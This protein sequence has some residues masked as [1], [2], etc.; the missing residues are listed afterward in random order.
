MTVKRTEQH[1]IRQSHPAWKTIDDYCFRSKNLYNYTNY[2]ARQELIE[3]QKRLHYYDMW[4]AVKDSE[5][6]KNMGS[7]VGIATIRMLEKAW[8]SFYVAIKDWKCSPQ[9]YLGRPKLP[10]Y[11]P[12]NGRYTLGI[13]NTK[14]KIVDGLIRFSWKP[15][16]SLNGRFYTKIPDGAKLMQCR[17]VPLV[18]SYAMEIVY[19]IEVKEVSGDPVRIAAIDLGVGNF[20]TITNNI[21]LQPIVIKGGVV[22]A[23]NQLYNK[24]RAKAVSNLAIKNGKKMSKRT[25][26]MQNKRTNR[27]KTQ[28]HRYSKGVI[29]YCAEN[30]IDTLVCGYNPEWKQGVS[31]RR[32][33]NQTFTAIPHFMFIQQLEYKCQNAGIRF[34]KT[35]ESYTSGTSAIDGEAPTAE[36]YDKSRRKHRGLFISNNGTPINADVN[37]SYQIMRK[38]FPNALVEGIA[39]IACYP[40]S[41]QIA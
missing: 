1:V 16:K 24:E 5:P 18:S 9:K 8:N 15:L 26:A 17:F 6:Y 4:Q 11:R 35:E 40:M 20:A 21:G 38:V 23:I 7:D 34:I 14:F 25:T 30:S 41:M 3:N 36:N 19:E 39:G 32:E 22:K 13:S 29:V 12:K 33:N 31:L 28:M 10:G 2:I 27:L 37:G